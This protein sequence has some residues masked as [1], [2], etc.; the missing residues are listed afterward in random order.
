MLP[1]HSESQLKEGAGGAGHMVMEGGGERL[2]ER[3]KRYQLLGM[4][5]GP[6]K[7]QCGL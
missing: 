4:L 6:E 3:Y 7:G 2:Y 5:S 1:P